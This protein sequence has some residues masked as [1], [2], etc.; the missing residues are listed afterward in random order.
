MV[1]LHNPGQPPLEDKVRLLMGPGTGFGFTFMTRPS[2]K[3][4]FAVYPSENSMTFPITFEPDHYELLKTIKELRSDVRY[5]NLNMVLSGNSMAAILKYL[6]TKQGIETSPLL[7]A[8]K[9]EDITSEDIAN[10][11]EK[12][13]DLLC[14]STIEFFM[15]FL[16]KHIRN[17]CTTFLCYG[18]VYL[19]AG[20]VEGSMFW[21]S[22]PE[23]K[24]KWL[25]AIFGND[26]VTWAI[27]RTPIR[28]I[29]A[30]DL[31]M[32][33]CYQYGKQNGLFE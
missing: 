3:D 5:T 26:M 27:K 31:G 6:K 24:A 17:S 9:L 25:E 8:K 7:E 11:A 12:N 15:M 10:Y 29:S 1:Y 21:L 4:K 20:V 16:A 13:D 14:I 2:E 33:G 19:C 30:S 28:F 23:N 22:K 18:G 32:R